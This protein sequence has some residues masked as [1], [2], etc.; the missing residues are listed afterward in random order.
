MLSFFEKLEKVPY[1]K[2]FG[3]FCLG[4]VYLDNEMP[5]ISKSSP[6]KNDEIIR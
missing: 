5:Q 4:I 1:D 2:L 3:L 6:T